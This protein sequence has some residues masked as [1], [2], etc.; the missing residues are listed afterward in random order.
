MIPNLLITALLVKT[1]QLFP[2]EN[3]GGGG[4]GI[5]QK[6]AWDC[7][8]GWPKSKKKPFVT[9]LDIGVGSSPWSPPSVPG[10]RL[11]HRRVHCTPSSAAGCRWSRRRSRSSSSTT[12]SSCRP[13]SGP[14]K[15]NKTECE[16]RSLWKEAC[17][18]ASGLCLQGTKAG[19]DKLESQSVT[20]G[21]DR[22]EE[23]QT[24][25]AMAICWDPLQPP[26][27]M[28]WPGRMQVP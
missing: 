2:K 24:T 6:H 8:K 19:E 27:G 12:H 5:L 21:K 25:V 1:V 22:Q 7:R 28:L 4:W 3:R 20:E 23:V 13:L 26:T 17:T 10:I 15:D 9:D 11:P 16:N 18:R 14:K